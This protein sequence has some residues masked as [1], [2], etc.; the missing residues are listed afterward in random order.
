MNLKEL[1]YFLNDKYSAEEHIK[2]N[3]CNFFIDNEKT[4]EACIFLCRGA[5]FILKDGKKNKKHFYLICDYY[6][7]YSYSYFTCKVDEFE[8]SYVE[9]FDLN[10][11]VSKS[12]ITF[13]YLSFDLGY[14]GMLNYYKSDYVFKIKLDF[15]EEYPFVAK[16]SMEKIK[17]LALFY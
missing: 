13:K 15:C 4:K 11:N 6:T 2:C 17:T 3:I 7:N 12:F 16:E 14:G 1:C 9:L 5:P 10:N 8:F